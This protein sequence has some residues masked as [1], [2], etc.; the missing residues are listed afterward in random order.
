MRHFDELYDIAA[1]RKGGTAALEA[2]LPV[3]ASAK[4]LANIPEDRWLA[5]LTKSVFQA[6][7]NWK[8]V[9]AKWPGFEHA[10]G[11]FDVGPIALM[12]DD[13]F[14][15]HLSDPGIIRNGAK[16]AA[17]RA[18]AAF[19]LELREHGGAGAVLG[20]WA[21]ED[22]AGLLAMMKKRGA[23]LGGATAQYALRSMARDGFILSGDVTA[24]LIAE[25]VIDAPAGSRRSM[26]AVQNA[27]NDW[28]GQSGRGLTQISRV[29]A[30]SV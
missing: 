27:F 13:T 1:T 30:M 28:M 17:L 2:L 4:D 12:D 22:F 25:G 6:G 18:N 23:R 14:D 8:V 29:L 3:S 10:F 26:A 7:F 11:R 24:R 9:E 20:G 15:S 21:S 16:I 19:L 5:Q